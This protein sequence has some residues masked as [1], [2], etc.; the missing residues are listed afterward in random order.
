MKPGP[1]D[2]FDELPPIANEVSVRIETRR[3][4]KKMTVIEGLDPH[5]TDLA[6]L[7]KELKDK[8]AA[9]GTHKE[10]HI[11]LQGE[12]TA[13]VTEFLEKRGYTVK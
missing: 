8:V 10:G 5:E 1:G 3:Y 4:G 7:T 9:G 2:I 11:E 6:V 13:K 12:H